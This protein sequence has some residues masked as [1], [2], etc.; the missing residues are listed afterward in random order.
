MTGS[1]P[2]SRSPAGEAQ[3][4]DSLGQQLI[5]ASHAEVDLPGAA[6]VIPDQRLARRHQHR[7]RSRVIVHGADVRD[8]L[9]LAHMAN[10][11]PHRGVGGCDA[12]GI[13]VMGVPC[14]VAG[15]QDEWIELYN[16]GDTAIDLGSWMVSGGEAASTALYRI[17]PDAVLAPV[18]PLARDLEQEM[19]ANF[20]HMGNTSMM[21]PV[22]G[23]YYYQR[24]GDAGLPALSRS[25]RLSS[26]LRRSG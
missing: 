16:G 23:W 10:D 26:C 15:A 4:V 22:D 21:K 20:A 5:R 11:V 19:A 24:T 9:G 1:N 25:S 7:Q 17:P 3:L 6:V 2:A 13:V 8:G 18:Q 12:G 14:R